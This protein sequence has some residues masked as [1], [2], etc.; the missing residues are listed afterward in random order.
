MQGFASAV[1]YATLVFI[2]ALSAAVFTRL[3]D[4]GIN[5]RHLLHGRTADGRLYFSP[6]RVQL[7]LFTV[8][9]ALSYLLNV[10][11][12]RGEGKLP[13]VPTTTLALLGGSHGVYLAGKA[14]SMFFAGRS[15]GE[16]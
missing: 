7:L 10:I 4:G 2:A 3:A 15:K 13:D 9:A 12:T 16:E 6:E 1:T 8:W 11:E 5:T 14:V